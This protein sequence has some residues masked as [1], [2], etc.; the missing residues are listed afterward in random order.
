M[1]ASILTAIMEN[2][3]RA[4]RLS[5]IPFIPAAFPGREEFWTVLAEL[6]AHGADIIEIGVPFS[7]PVADGPQVAEA[8]RQALANG[9]GLD[10]IFEGLARH[11]AELAS[12][13]VLMGYV[14]PFIQYG[15]ARAGQGRPAGEARS[16]MA[17]SLE[18][19]A[20]TMSRAGVA[21]LIVP[22]LPLEESGPWLAA[23]KPRGLDL[24]ALVGPNTSLERMK[25][26]AAGGGGGYV[27]VVSV[28]GVTGLREA[29]PPEAAA[30]LKRAR[31]A[32]ALPLALGFGLSSPAQLQ[33]LPPEDRPEGAVFGSALIRHLSGGGAVRDFMAPWL[34]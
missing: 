10:Y 18:F 17:A 1:T 13:L 33:N 34:S 5:L 12:N 30:T 11:R 2:N 29:L 19:L 7:D 23:F 6:T 31:Q 28:M 25:A 26:Y 32:F 20:E 22:D 4:G 8:S 21:G 9:G 24:I 15:W 27:Y 14:N 3:R 16:V